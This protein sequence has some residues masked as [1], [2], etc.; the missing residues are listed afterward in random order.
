MTKT[1]NA[2]RAHDECGQSIWYDNVRRSLLQSGH[3][4][5]LV[6]EG[7]RGCTSNPTIFEKAIAGSSD[8]DAAL[9]PLVSEGRSV[10]EIYDTLVVQDIRDT[11]DALRAV[12][13]S[14]KGADGYVS[15]EV[16]PHLAT[17]TAGTVVEAKRLSGLVDRP[18]LMIK[19]PA[20]DQGLPAV[21]EVIAT[22]ISV[23]VTLIF[24]VEQYR[25]VAGAY[26]EGLRRAHAAG[27]D[28]SRIAS[29]ASFFV[30]RIDSSV[31]ALL[32][33]KSKQSPQLAAR[34]KPLFGKA[35][36]ANAK[37]AYRVFGEVF[38]SAEFVTLKQAGARPQRVLW[39]STGT[40]NPEYP[41]TLYVDQLL[42]PDTVNT[43][44]PQTLDAFQDHGT[45]A[46]T[47]QQDIEGADKTIAELVAL[48]IPLGPVC[49]KL[50][51]EGVAAFAKSMT[52]LMDVIAQRRAALLK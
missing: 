1:A 23:N 18:N 24:S 16:S 9:Q 41:D 33:E 4:A 46:S 14:S 52:S 36:I 10:D 8:Y 25:K 43:V 47:L 21:S 31:D 34:A 26:I 13:D 30:S 48:G 19:I 15:I 44:P 27:V 11:A 39:A 32:Q 37:Q 6:A 29:V 51:A 38:G 35:A 40:K 45:V 20:T 17:D 22:G 7:V 5:R 28:L 50:L 49:D 42:G 12:Y 2:Q 3:F